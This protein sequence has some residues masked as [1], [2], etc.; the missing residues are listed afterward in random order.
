MQSL[1]KEQILAKLAD[2]MSRI[3]GFGVRRIG[4]FGST[5]RN[6]HDGSSDIDILV[7][8]DVKT[9]DNY[10]DLKDF[11]EGLFERPV[12]LVISDALKPRLRQNILTETVYAS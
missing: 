10:M 8:F 6:E 2:N 3:H 9:F 7:E 4:L 5:V 12:D 1:S 11:L